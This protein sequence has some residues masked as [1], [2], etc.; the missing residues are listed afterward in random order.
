MTRRCPLPFLPQTRWMLLLSAIMPFVVPPLL[1]A[2]SAEPDYRVTNPALKL[3]SIDTD[4]KESFLS[5]GLDGAGRLF[6]GARE[7]LFVYEPQPGGLYGQ[8]QELYRFPK[9]SWV[10]MSSSAGMICIPT[11][12]RVVSLSRRG[13]EKPAWR[14]A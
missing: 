3:I 5:M 9:D 6:V 7:A 14:S 13:C 8:R 1:E 2:A 11:T 10:T 12:G 4:K